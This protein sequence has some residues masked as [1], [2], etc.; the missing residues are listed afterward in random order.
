[1]LRPCLYLTICSSTKIILHKSVYYNP[2]ILWLFAT[3]LLMVRY[4]M[5][6]EMYQIILNI[7][8]EIPPKIFMPN[9]MALS[10]ICYNCR[11]IFFPFFRKFNKIEMKWREPR[12]ENYV[13]RGR[14]DT[15]RSEM[16]RRF[17]WIIGVGRG[18]LIWE[19]LF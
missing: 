14:V 1:M 19:K 17:R 10:K 9:I 15:I 12:Y 2:C 3:K 7:R 13:I 11:F 4:R 8:T 5:F 16:A 18:A 6:D